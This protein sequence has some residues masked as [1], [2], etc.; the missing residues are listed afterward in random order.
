MRL[1][2]RCRGRDRSSPGSIPTPRRSRVDR[3]KHRAATTRGQARPR[4]RAAH[5]QHRHRGPA[6]RSRAGGAQCRARRCATRSWRWSAA[7]SSR[8]SP[9]SSA[10]CPS[11][12]ATTSPASRRSPPSTTGPA[13]SSISGCPSASPPPSRSARR[14]RR[15]RSPTP[16]D[17]FEGT[18]RPSTTALTRRAA[19]LWVQAKIANPADSLRAGMSFQVTMRFPG[20][21]YPAVSPLAMQWGTDGAFSGRRRRQGQ[22][23]A[24]AH[25]P[26]Q[27]RDRAGRRADR[28]RRH[29]GDRGRPERTRGQRGP[30]RRAASAAAA[31]SRRILTD[32]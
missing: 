20:D 3:A 2:H 30:H 24:G 16:S 21:T 12:P 18:F 32:A 1:G 15:R 6:D 5:L 28:Q 23:R 11:K 26:A 31:R 29:G 27:H 22:A 10:S 7:R 17:V 25:R 13:S 8:R 19:R 14:S 4:Q 9:A